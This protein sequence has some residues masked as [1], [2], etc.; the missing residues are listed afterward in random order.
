MDYAIFYIGSAFRFLVV[1]AFTLWALLLLFLILFGI[2]NLFMNLS[3][4][5][6]PRLFKKTAK[7]RE[8]HALE[9]QLMKRS[10]SRHYKNYKRPMTNRKR[11]KTARIIENQLQK[12]R[13]FL[14]KGIDK[15]F[16]KKG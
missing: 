2:W 9:S 7:R 10:T 6:F 16:F 8:N 4:F 3:A 15:D 14:N 12:N 13:M 5:L 1:A 11:Y